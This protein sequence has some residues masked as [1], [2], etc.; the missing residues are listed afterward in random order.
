MATSPLPPTAI[1][2]D[3]VHHNSQ[4]LE[5]RFLLDLSTGN[6]LLSG[7]L[8]FSPDVGCVKTMKVTVFPFLLWV[9]RNSEMI[10]KPTI[11]TLLD[12]LPSKLESYFFP[13]ILT[14]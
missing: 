13:L 3:M 11:V 7:K 2:E 5:E 9:A 1:I 12:L 10:C 6:V 14:I 4:H 8:V